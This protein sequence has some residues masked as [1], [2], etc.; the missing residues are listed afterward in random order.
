MNKT[1]CSARYDCCSC[2][3]FS[4]VYCNGGCLLQDNVKVL[5][6]AELGTQCMAEHHEQIITRQKQALAELRTKLRVADKSKPG[7]M[8]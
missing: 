7:G 4:F 1:Y 6:L 8:L 3:F 2:G 5:K